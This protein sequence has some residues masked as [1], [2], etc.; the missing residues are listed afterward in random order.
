MIL[1]KGARCTIM[2]TQRSYLHSRSGSQRYGKGTLGTLSVLGA[3]S[4]MTLAALYHN[5]PALNEAA[6]DD[7]KNRFMQTKLHFTAIDPSDNRPFEILSQKAINAIMRSGE[8]AYKFAQPIKNVSGVYVNSLRSNEPI[9]DHYSVD[10]IGSTKVIAGVYDGH[11][12]PQC[13]ILIKRK[14]PIYVAQHLEGLPMTRSI[15]KVMG[16]L[17]SA[18]EELDYHI[19]QRFIDIFPKD[20][21]KLSAGDIRSAVTSRPDQ[22]E[23]RRIIEEAIHGSCASVA[24]VDGDDVYT[25]N[26]GDSRSV[27]VSVDKD[28]KWHG[29]RLVDE[30]TP[31]RPA[32]R[33]FMESQH[34]ASE[35]NGLIK[36]NRVFG[37]IAVGGAFGDIMYKVPVEYQTAVLPNIPADIYRRFARYHHRI[38]ANYRTPPYLYSKPIVTHHKLEENDRFIVVASDGLWWYTGKEDEHSPDGDQ[39]VADIMS[40]W[41]DDD[42]DE[43]PN[44][45]THLMKHAFILR[46][47]YDLPDSAPFDESVEISKLLTKQ[48]SRGFRDDITIVVIQ[49]GKGEKSVTDPGRYGEI[50]EAQEVDVNCPKL[51]KPSKK[52]WW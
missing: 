26:T 22:V 37:L 38:I 14:I 47:R 52:G 50:I 41:K 20:I 23:T 31:A 51:Y 16:A 36:R 10:T 13:S 27:V 34:P 7:D 6:K 33:K 35:T 24:Y 42:S 49:L 11:I 12:G 4:A 45:S 9:E 8:V 21:S 48:P 39:A 25:A 32:W 2:H 43:L 28:G 5:S 29:R 30:Q 40:K 1:S 3:A 15:E 44:P 19:Q 17:S 18:F 46:R